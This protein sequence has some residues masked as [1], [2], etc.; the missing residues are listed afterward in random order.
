VITI[1]RP[2]RHNRCDGS[3]RECHGCLGDESCRNKISVERCG[4]LGFGNWRRWNTCVYLVEQSYSER[5]ARRVPKRRRD[6]DYR[7][8][9]GDGRVRTDQR[10]RQSPDRIRDVPAAALTAYTRSEDRTRALQRLPN[11]SRE[12]DRSGRAR[13]GH[14]EIGAT[15]PL[16][17][18][19]FS[20]EELSR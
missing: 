19:T 6:K 7:W 14:W 8:H 16:Y 20:G 10:I 5:R 9:H 13:A 3:G 18:P 12:T 4:R 17:Q 1:S 2:H 15:S 11:V